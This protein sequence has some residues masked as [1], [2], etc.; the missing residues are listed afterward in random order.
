MGSEM[1]RLVKRA[2][3]RERATLVGSLRGI[4][5]ESSA[6]SIISITIGLN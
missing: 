3:K 1:T 2:G 4:I 6:T 5:H